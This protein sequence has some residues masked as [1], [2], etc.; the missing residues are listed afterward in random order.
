MIFMLYELATGELKYNAFAL[1]A[2]NLPVPAGY[3][4]V[5]GE[6]NPNT[7][8][9]VD[10]AVVSR[11]TLQLTVSADEIAADGTATSSISGIP[12]GAYIA[13]N[14]KSAISDGTP[15]IFSTDMLG[16]N[17]IRVS[18]FPYVYKE[19]TINGI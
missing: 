7:R 9:V 5:E 6:H 10:S 8:Y 12:A 18:V 11:P 13:C 2:E 15:I 19:I 16:D 14:G 17:K 1:S 3:G 4:Y